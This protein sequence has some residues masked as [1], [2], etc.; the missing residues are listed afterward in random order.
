MVIKIRPIRDRML[1]AGYDVLE[2][3]EKLEAVA[4]V[5]KDLLDKGIDHEDCP[6]IDIGEA[7]EKLEE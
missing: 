4:K 3:I 6:L 1:S 7:L 5:A 2:Y